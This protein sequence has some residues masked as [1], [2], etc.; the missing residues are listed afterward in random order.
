VDT[1]W[2][3]RKAMVKFEPDKG[4]TTMDDV[5]TQSLEDDT[6]ESLC[7]VC[8]QPGEVIVCDVKGCDKV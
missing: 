5:T 3:A 1:E 7:F 2:S 8:S 6:S 4:S